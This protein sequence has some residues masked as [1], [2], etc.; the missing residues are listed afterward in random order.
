MSFGYSVSDIIGLVQLAWT[1]VEGARRACGEYDD[2][3]R[4]LSS[5]HSVLNHLHFELSNPESLVNS[6]EDVRRAEL[7]NHIRGCERHLGHMNTILIKYNSLSDKDRKGKQL[8][9]KFRFGNGPVHVVAKIRGKISTYTAAI[10]MS[11]HLL[12]LGSQGRVERRLTGQ[13]GDL[14]G[15][16]ESINLLVAKASSQS[17]EG[18]VMT[19]YANDETAFWRNLRRELVNDGYPSKAI[20]GQKKLIQDY[21]RELGSRGVLDD[22]ADKPWKPADVLHHVEESPSTNRNS[23]GQILTQEE[24]AH[25][26]NI[27]AETPQLPP[28]FSPSSAQGQQ[29]RQEGNQGPNVSSKEPQVQITSEGDTEYGTAN[30]EY[31]HDTIDQETQHEQEAR[32]ATRLFFPDSEPNL[33]TNL[34]AHAGVPTIPSVETK[35]EQ[36]WPGNAQ[37]R[38]S[39]NTEHDSVGF[40]SGND[41]ETFT[42]QEPSQVESNQPEFQHLTPEMTKMQERI[43]YLEELNRQQEQLLQTVLSRENLAKAPK[44]KFKDCVGR[45]FAFPIEIAKNWTVSVANPFC[46]TNSDW[47]LANGRVDTPGV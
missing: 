3:T 15:I 7:S 40:S 4:E 36:A 21:I 22:R 9:K 20:Q 32:E 47:K 44:V 37:N 31:Q 30:F 5:L 8:W 27:S 33:S 24:A 38:V 23:P 2:L 25:E 6:A 41:S 13:A 10:S 29:Q 16:R 26:T 45:N 18:S 46:P 28:A 43:S 35:H 34:D 14:R 11:L 12:A 17:P 1:A 19:D 39:A 42:T